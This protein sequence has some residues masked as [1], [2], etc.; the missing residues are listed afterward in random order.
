MHHDTRVPGFPGST[1]VLRDP[2]L[3]V[4][5]GPG[6]RVPRVPL[7]STTEGGAIMMQSLVCFKFVT[8]SALSHGAR[9]AWQLEGK[10]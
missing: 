5:P 1:R 4:T 10:C 2:V 8:G 7:S 3:L 6:T 9:T